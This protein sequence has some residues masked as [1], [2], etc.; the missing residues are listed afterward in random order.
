MV[1]MN[2]TTWYYTFLTNLLLISFVFA[3]FTPDDPRFGEQWGHTKVQAPEAW[4]I[5]TGQREIIVGVIDTGVNWEH[6]DLL[7]KI[8]INSDEIAGN[9][10]DDDNN[11]YVDDVRG[12]D[13]YTPDNNPHDN[14]SFGG[15]TKGHGSLVAGII[16]ANIDNGKGIA[17]ICDNVKIMPLKVI[18]GQGSPNGNL[19]KAINYA[20]DNGADI[21]NAS[22]QNWDYS[23]DVYN[24]LQNAMNAGI[25]VIT[26]AGNDNTNID[27]NNNY[28]SS[29]DLDNIIPVLATNSNDSRRSK[30][31]YGSTTV[32][33]GGAGR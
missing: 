9:D 6:P 32:D 24:A 12:Y 16:A 11:D 13:F 33:I 14:F 23:Q 30:S 3:Q 25:L 19:V 5:S 29:Y 1:K 8:W 15:S 18:N 21:I 28:P 17:G 4:E 20:V 2:N 27:S 10:E 7:G 31:N 22:L 26:C